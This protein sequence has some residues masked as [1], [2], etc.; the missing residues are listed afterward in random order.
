M[1]PV[2]IYEKIFPTFAQ[3][4]KPVYALLKPIGATLK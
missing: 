3:K 4:I 2:S 1:F